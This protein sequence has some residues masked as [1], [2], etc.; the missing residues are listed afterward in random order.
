MKDSWGELLFAPIGWLLTMPMLA[1]IPAAVFL[2]YY[3]A[4]RNAAAELGVPGRIRWNLFA[5]LLWAGYIVYESYMLKW[6]QT[7]AGAPIRIDLV[8]VWPVLWLLSATALWSSFRFEVSAGRDELPAPPRR[9]SAPVMEKNRR[10]VAG[11]ALGIVS[12]YLLHSVLFSILSEL[13]RDVLLGQLA[14]LLLIT[15]FSAFLVR[16]HRWAKVCL[17]A[18]FAF[19]ALIQGFFLLVAMRVPREGFLI[20]GVGS[21]VL[22]GFYVLFGACLL[23]SGR[24]EQHLARG[25]AAYR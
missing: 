21:L 22:L 3:F 24:L 19:G 23:F 9:L 15:M 17:V 4:R 7:I 5:G 20:L 14:R 10:F 1:A 13:D 16:G 11:L 2:G 18:W 6:S 12:V 8:V 25:P